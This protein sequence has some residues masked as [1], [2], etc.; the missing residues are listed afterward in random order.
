MA[1]NGT[2]LEKYKDMC[3]LSYTNGLDF[4]KFTYGTRDGKSTTKTR[5]YVE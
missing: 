3:P 5:A 2:G 1:V 4:N